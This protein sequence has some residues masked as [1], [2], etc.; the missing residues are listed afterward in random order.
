MTA[1][2]ARTDD[3]PGE[4]TSFPH[5]SVLAYAKWLIGLALGGLVISACGSSLGA[6]AYVTT[7]S[8]IHYKADLAIVVDHDATLGPILATSQG[9]PLYAFSKDR[10]VK[11]FCNGACAQIWRPAYGTHASVVPG[12][13]S[14]LVGYIVRKSGKHQLTYNGY[15]LYTFTHDTPHQKAS[16]ENI[17]AFGGLWA[18]ISVTGTAEPLATAKKAS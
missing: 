5:R 7:P 14:T 15:P 4:R 18:V 9:L 13:N 2:P 10:G 1:I 16:G 3:L 6:T 8:T 11:S 17:H 12:L